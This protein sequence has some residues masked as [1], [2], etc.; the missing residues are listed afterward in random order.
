MILPEYD[1]LAKGLGLQ[2][3]L[4]GVFQDLYIHDVAA[5]GFGCGLRPRQ[6]PNSFCTPGGVTAAM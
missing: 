3:V 2:Y 6:S 5:T 1:V 4:R